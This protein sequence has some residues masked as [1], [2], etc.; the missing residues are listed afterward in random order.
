MHFNLLNAKF[1]PICMS[2]LVELFCRY[3]NLMHAF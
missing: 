3:L 2:Q 1:I